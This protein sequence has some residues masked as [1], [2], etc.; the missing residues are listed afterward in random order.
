MSRL[1]TTDNRLPITSVPRIVPISDEHQRYKGILCGTRS[2]KAA[3]E[4]LR[5]YVSLRHVGADIIIQY[6][7]NL[8][9]STL[10]AEVLTK[11]DLTHNQSSVEEA[12]FILKDV[13]SF[14]A[15]DEIC[16]S[17][18]EYFVSERAVHWNNI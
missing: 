18:R 7:S 4:K 17:D 1:P 12:G 11:A 16:L 14:G 2:E 3:E 9:H 15:R 8:M 5:N 6:H 10:P 13:V